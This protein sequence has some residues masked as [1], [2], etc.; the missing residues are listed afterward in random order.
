MTY[1]T[2]I[3]I[4]LYHYWLLSKCRSNP[5]IC[6]LWQCSVHNT[7]NELTFGLTPRSLC[8]N[9]N[10]FATLPSYGP[11]ECSQTAFGALPNGLSGTLINCIL[12]T[13]QQKWQR[14]S[15]NTLQFFL[16]NTLTIQMMR[17][18]CASITGNKLPLSQRS[19][20]IPQCALSCLLYSTSFFWPQ[21]L[22]FVIII[23]TVPPI[24]SYMSYWHFLLY[25]WL[26]SS[27]ASFSVF[28]E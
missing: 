21:H 5:L 17:V 6:C 22:S 25:L 9:A 10:T 11:Q 28:R 18:P 8:S 23:N 20:L 26:S 27:S 19:S 15:K 24:I 16:L 7:I 13:K 14:I 4:L 12:T 2:H 3:C 1:K